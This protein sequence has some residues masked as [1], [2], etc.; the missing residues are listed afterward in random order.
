MNMVRQSR[1]KPTDADARRMHL[2]SGQK[3]A[4][5]ITAKTLEDALKPAKIKPRKPAK[6]SK[7]LITK[8]DTSRIVVVAP[9]LERVTMTSKK[10]SGL[11]AKSWLET[12]RTSGETLT[13]LPECK[14]KNLARKLITTP[15]GIGAKSRIPKQGSTNNKSRH[16]LPHDGQPRFQDGFCIVQG[17]LP[18]LGKRR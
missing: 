15:T 17:G 3:K 1:G 13:P 12:L 7:P 8:S 14:T 18:E 9:G 11:S 16:V 5:K 4:L 2:R 10:K 6:T